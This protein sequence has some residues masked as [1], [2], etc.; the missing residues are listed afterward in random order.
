MY[1]EHVPSLKQTN[2]GAQTQRRA[3]SSE[4]GRVIIELSYEEARRQY[5]DKVDEVMTK[6]R[7]G[8]S[9][10]RDAAPE[11]LEWSIEYGV[12]VPGQLVTFADLIVG[13]VEDPR[14]RRSRM[15][16][17]ERVEEIVQGVTAYLRGKIGRFIAF[18]S[19]IEGCPE[20]VRAAIRRGV[21]EDIAE[22]AR[23]AALSPEERQAEAEEALRQ[24]RKM[25]GFMEIRIGD[26]VEA[27]LIDGF[28]QVFS[29]PLED[30]PPRQ[31]KHRLH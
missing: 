17:D 26:D 18:S 7:K 8:K 28:S 2:V 1:K 31:R 15:S 3:R 20:E 4:G 27:A 19:Q 29:E 16:L 14:E 5:P 10:H 23:V 9:R 12:L 30:E 24:L 21:E 13:R 11:E 22:E 25:P 6:L